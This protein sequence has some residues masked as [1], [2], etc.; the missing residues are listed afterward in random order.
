VGDIII[1]KEIISLVVSLLPP[2]LKFELY[3]IHISCHFLSQNLHISYKGRPRNLQLAASYFS[4][5]FF[6]RSRPGSFFD[7][8]AP[9]HTKLLVV[10][11]TGESRSSKLL[12]MSGLL[13]SKWAVPGLDPIRD[14]KARGLPGTYREE[15]EQ[16]SNMKSGPF[17]II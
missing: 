2:S 5:F 3:H 12:I 11:C 16:V 6:C 1:Y 7:Q 14:R 15:Q 17:Y 13:S 10:T 8:K 9:Q 4:I